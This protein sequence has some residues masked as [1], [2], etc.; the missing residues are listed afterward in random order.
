MTARKASTIFSEIVKSTGKE[1]NLGHKLRLNKDRNWL[2]ALVL[3]SYAN[4]VARK[5]ATDVDDAIVSAFDNAGFGDEMREQGKLYARMP[6]DARAQL[7]PTAFAEMAPGSAY[8]GADLVANLPQIQSAILAMPNATDIDVVGVHQGTAAKASFRR[9]R[10]NVVATHA[11]E[12]LRAVQPDDPAGATDDPFS[13]KA[14]S[15][16]CSD[17]TGIDWLG[18][19]EPYWIFGS[20]GAGV[21]VTTKSRVFSDIDSGDNATFAADEGWLWGQ[22]GTAAPLPADDIGIL[23]SLWEHD[24]GDPTKVKAAVAGAFAA[25]AGIL[26]L[27]GAASWV[28]AVVAGVGAVVQWLLS[29]LDDDHISD[30]TFIFSRQT[31][32]DQIGKAGQSFQLSRQFTDGDGDYTLT[33]TVTHVAP[34]ST[35][36]VVPTVVGMTKASAVA[37]IQAAG[38]VA[39]STTSQESDLSHLGHLGDLSDHTVSGDLQPVAAG[40]RNEASARPAPASMLAPIGGGGGNGGPSGPPVVFVVS[41]QTPV[42]GTTVARGSTVHLTVTRIDNR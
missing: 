30:Q 35:T 22:Q 16:H 42:G 26:A 15:F 1:A 33:I 2:L 34:Q 24:D 18:S 7:F 31:I 41:D 4:E 13:I 29:Y 32:I 5:P 36:V 11:S 37:R 3:N 10:P 12:L 9:P 14:T 39:T 23:I 6:A 38:L 40:R 21:A 8:T 19:D 25:A 27:S 28:G 20:I 17:E